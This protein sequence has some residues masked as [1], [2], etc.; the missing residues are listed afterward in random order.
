MRLSLGITAV[1]AA[2]A[3]VKPVKSRELPPGELIEACHQV[4]HQLGELLKHTQNTDKF[5]ASARRKLWEKGQAAKAHD[6]K[7]EK[8]LRDSRSRFQ[9]EA[10]R[11]QDLDLTNC[12][13]LYA[14]LKLELEKI[15]KGLLQKGTG[16][17]SSKANSSKAS[18][19][20]PSAT[21]SSNPRPSYHEL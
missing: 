5:D 16:H 2:S 15:E 1:L 18:S 12:F 9:E 19:K 3:L 14:P 7:F 11:K 4:T 20:E 17:K 21:R 13:Y 6:Q 10:T 8:N